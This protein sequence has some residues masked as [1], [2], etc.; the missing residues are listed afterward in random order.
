[1]VSHP[2]LGSDPP[3]GSYRESGLHMVGG[4]GGGGRNSFATYWFELI[5]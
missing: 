5:T 2:D 4:G 1:M 3:I